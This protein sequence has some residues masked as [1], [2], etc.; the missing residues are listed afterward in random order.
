[1]ER[2]IGR[3]REALT[4]ICLKQSS[5]PAAYVINHYGLKDYVLALLKHINPDGEVLANDWFRTSTGINIVIVARNDADPKLRGFRGD[6]V[7][8]H[9]QCLVTERDWEMLD[10]IRTLRR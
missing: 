10:F 6:V 5:S 4:D 2:N 3:T 8:D 1:M 9:Y 7:L